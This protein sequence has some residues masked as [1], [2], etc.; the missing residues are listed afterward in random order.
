MLILQSSERLG[1]KLPPFL[2]RSFLG[3]T[4]CCS[5]TQTWGNSSGVNIHCITHTTPLP[6]RRL[7]GV[8]G[9]PGGTSGNF[10]RHFKSSSFLQPVCVAPQP[11]PQS[12]LVQ[13]E[14]EAS[15]NGELKT[16][17]TRKTNEELTHPE[18][19]RPGKAAF[20]RCP[21]I[22]VLQGLSNH[23]PPSLWG[24][25]PAALATDRKSCIL[26]LPV[27]QAGLTA[28]KPLVEWTTSVLL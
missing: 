24:W 6:T 23:Q 22:S 17:W 20:K 1:G 8:T 11:T 10:R 15:R 25:T 7:G 12:A 13:K 14:M 21:R 2:K 16:H 9:E 5:K 4:S 28:R 26:R 19:K 27:D 3:L 18:P